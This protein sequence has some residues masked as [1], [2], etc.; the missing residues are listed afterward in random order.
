MMMVIC[1]ALCTGINSHHFPQYHAS[2]DVRYLQ[3]NDTL[4]KVIQM[5]D[6]MMRQLK[7]AVLR[8]ANVC[9]LRVLSVLV[10]FQYQ[11][12][13]NVLLLPIGKGTHMCVMIETTGDERLV[14]RTGNKIA[15]FRVCKHQPADDA[16]H[17]IPF[18]CCCC[19]CCC[20]V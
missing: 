7:C 15:R 16:T 13:R 12:V 3:E 10:E 18:F 19:C 2:E 17:P 11:S 4:S 14:E 5:V 20:H 9:N 8:G 1:C 6:A